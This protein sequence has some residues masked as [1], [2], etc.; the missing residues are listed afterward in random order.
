MLFSVSHFH[1][2]IH[3]SFL[4]R[5]IIIICCVVI[6]INH[7]PFPVPFK[8]NQLFNISHLAPLYALNFGIRHQ[9]TSNN[10]VNCSLLHV[11]SN[12]M[13][14]FILRW[15]AHIHD[16]FIN[17]L[18]WRN[19]FNSL[20][21]EFS[22]SVSFWDWISSIS[23]NAIHF[24]CEDLWWFILKYTCDEFKSLIECEQLN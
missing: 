10:I 5:F 18:K 19:S 23:T 21:D 17:N 16:L 7:L 4:F 22:Y 20:S 14:K 1:I 2:L 15:R 24:D 3:R 8:F 11:P 6:H 12:P 13:R 9:I